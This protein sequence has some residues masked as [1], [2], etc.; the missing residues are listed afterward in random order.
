MQRLMADTK[1]R[2]YL[3]RLSPEDGDEAVR[4]Y[5][6]YVL[7]RIGTL[8]EDPALRSEFLQQ[9]RAKFDGMIDG[10]IDGG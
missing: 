5:L 1:T 10:M 7:Q 8:A 4:A 6:D 3:P 2:E 9:Y